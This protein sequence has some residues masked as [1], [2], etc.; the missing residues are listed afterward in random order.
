MPQFR[1]RALQAW[2]EPGES[3]GDF[4]IRMSQ[5][6]REERDLAVEKLRSKYASRLRSIEKRLQTA[7]QRL[8]REQSQYE[9]QKLQ[10]AISF[11]ATVLGA[12][13]GRKVASVGNIGRATT[14]ARGASRVSRERAD[15][16]RAQDS[17]EDVLAERQALEQEL[18]REM[19]AL[20]DRH[21]PASLEI[22]ATEIR[23]RKSDIAAADPV[24]VWVPTGRDS[25][26]LPR[27]L[28]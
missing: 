7:Q 4:R 12:V 28:T 21:D 10:T 14:A 18:E 24:L 23:P 20:R 9:Q 26:G 3:E 22:E 17:I 2:S 6:A 11:G 5:T 19:D 8:S 27:R 25:S 13:F 1:C 16:S 15:I